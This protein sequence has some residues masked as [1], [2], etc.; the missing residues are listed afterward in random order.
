MWKFG[1]IIY[2]GFYAT[3]ISKVP[4]HIRNCFSKV[5]SYDGLLC[6]R[7]QDCQ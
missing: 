3:E 2:E 5:R 7:P 1:H 4:Y 6:N